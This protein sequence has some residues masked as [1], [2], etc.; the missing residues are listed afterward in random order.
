MARKLLI[1]VVTLMLAA[2][3]VRPE[4]AN[5]PERQALGAPPHVANTLRRACYDCHSNE[6]QWPSYS[7]VAPF[8]W[9]VAKHVREGRRKLNFSTIKPDRLPL[10]DICEEMQKR[11]MPLPAY[12]LIHRDAVTTDGD[13]KAVCAWA[14]ESAQ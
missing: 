1:G 11:R 14:E 13:V 6:T 7:N 2:Q 5:P 4:R 8:S 9:L 12:T 3:L 10:D